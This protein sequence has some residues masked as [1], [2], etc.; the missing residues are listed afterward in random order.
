MTTSFYC[1]MCGTKLFSKIPKQ[2]SIKR[3]VCPACGFIFYNNPKPTAV[4]IIQRDG[5]VLL[6][7]RKYDPY[8]GYWDLPGGFM[9]P[10]ETVEKALKREIW[11]ETALEVN[12][13]RYYCSYPNN[14]VYGTFESTVIGIFFLAE[15][16]SGKAKAGDDVLDLAWFAWDNLPS[17]IAPFTDVQ[18]ALSKR[19]KEL[20]F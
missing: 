4:A 17:M 12:N 19:K 1:L 7:K 18:Q 10:G 14:Y 16:E 3:L 11:E 13:L 2:E 20:G 9:E 6:T 8:Q 15:I 5:K